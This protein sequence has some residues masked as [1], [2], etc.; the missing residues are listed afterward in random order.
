MDLTTPPLDWP[1]RMYPAMRGLVALASLDLTGR[2]RAGAP[3]PRATPAM[4]AAFE[5]T[6]GLRLDTDHRRF[7]QHANGW[8]T[9]WPIAMFGLPELADQNRMARLTSALVVTGDL[10]A[11][12]LESSDVYPVAWAREGGTAV[13]VRLGRGRA[14]EVIWFEGVQS[15]I[16]REFSAF[17]DAA[18]SR[19]LA[20]TGPLTGGASADDAPVR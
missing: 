4:I 2:I 7:L 8:P 6:T 15:T 3:R 12:G 5:H 17:F 9:L 10:A 19:L 16:Y 18:A 20:V 1:T 11:A 14:G 13:V